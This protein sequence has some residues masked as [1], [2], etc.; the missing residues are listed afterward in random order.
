VQQVQQHEYLMAAAAVQAHERP[1]VC[2]SPKAQRSRTRE[3]KRPHARTV[4]VDAMQ[5]RQMLLPDARE[6]RQREW[7]EQRQRLD[8]VDVLEFADVEDRDKPALCVGLPRQGLRAR[9]DAVA[10]VALGSCVTSQSR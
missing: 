7:A 8:V 9:K 2:E 4:D 1:S 6:A 5:R 3:T 10:T